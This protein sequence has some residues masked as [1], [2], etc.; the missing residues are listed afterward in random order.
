MLEV[1]AIG[2]KNAGKDPDNKNLQANVQLNLIGPTQRAQDPRNTKDNH[3]YRESV[4]LRFELSK[5]GYRFFELLCLH[6]YQLTVC[7]L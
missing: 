5:L 1:V 7:K 2:R 3:I 4:E 6:E